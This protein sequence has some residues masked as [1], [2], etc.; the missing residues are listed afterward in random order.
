M[1]Y[2]VMPDLTPLEYAAL[3][4]DIANAGAVLVAVELDEAGA[5]LDGHHRVR[6]WEELRQDGHDLPD[7]PRVVRRGLSE[8]QKRA[9]AY[10]LNTHRRHLTRE[11]RDEVM[12]DM[13]ANGMTYQEIADAVGVSVFT[14]HR[15][16]NDVPILEIKNGV[17]QIRPAS[18]NRQPDEEHTF[19]SSIP[20]QVEDADADANADD[21][22]DE[23]PAVFVI[24]DQW[25]SVDTITV[26]HDEELAAVK[27]P[28][29]ANNSGNNEWYTPREYIDAARR[30][31]G[32]IDLDPA[33]SDLANQVVEAIRYYTADDD[34]LGFS[35]AGN[36]WMNPPYA[37]GLVDR[38][39]A[40]YAEH[41]RAGDIQQGIVLVNN[42]TETRWFSALVD[43]GCAV[44][45]PRTRVKFWAP[46]GSGAAPLQ[47]QAI[48]YSGPNVDV[49][50][51]EFGAFGWGARW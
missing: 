22:A 38:F 26:A 45:F 37:A 23:S 35:W 2:Q 34:G 16:A 4:A 7:Y 30:V 19:Q 12:R 8:Q 10:R 17:G 3:K 50:L 33:S 28:H 41:V 24:A 29:V 44:V 36:V 1:E 9:H 11:Q 25:G 6:A 21:T 5:I 31:M 43:A 51:S 27:R 46:D 20:I 13:R 40:K 49:F 48:I 42:A 14:A 18:Y 32:R 47:G 39:C 15:A